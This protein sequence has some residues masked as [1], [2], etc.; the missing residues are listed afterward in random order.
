MRVWGRTF[1][2]GAF[3]LAIGV[4]GV[5]D[6]AYRATGVEAGNGPQRWQVIDSLLAAANTLENLNSL[7]LNQP[8][9]QSLR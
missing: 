8:N 9:A 3:P 7:S 2:E 6:R 1:V 4:T 5:T